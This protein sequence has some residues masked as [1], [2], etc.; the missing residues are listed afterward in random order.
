MQIYKSFS[1][2]PVLLF[3]LVILTFT[4]YAQDN[5][6]TKQIEL[7]NG[8]KVF[9]Y[10]RHSVPL[11]NLTFAVNCGSKDE[12]E[13]TSGIVHI[14]EHYIMFR[15]TEFRNGDELAQDIREHGAYFNAH[16]SRDLAYFEMTLPSKNGD[17]GLELQK[18]ILF[19]LK[20][21]QEELDEEKE[22]ILEE[23][24]KIFDDPM[25]YASAMAYQTLFAGHPYQNPIYGNKEA[26]KNLTVDQVRAFYSRFFTPNNS[27]LVVLGDFD[28]SDMEEKVKSLYGDLIRKDIIDTKYENISS[29]SE[30]VRIEKEMDVNL[31]YLV[32]GMIGPDY[33]HPDR[34]SID[35]LSEILGRGVN[36]LLYKPLSQRRL[37]TN[38]LSLSYGANKN[39]GAIFVSVS[40]DPKN[41]NI[42]EKEIIKYL[43]SVRRE[44]F[45]KD[46]FAGESQFYAMDYLEYAKNQIKF[47][48]HESQ[49]EGLSVALSLS[50]YLL[51]DESSQ[52]GSFLENIE[53][54]SSSDLRKAGGRYLGSGR[55][56]IV[57]ITPPKK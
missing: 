31:G 35:L 15:G 16:T 30:S 53:K 50:K 13:K 38:S 55:Y 27:A 19:N 56:V 48:A 14:L 45:S 33:N 20:L 32:I 28:I 44:S 47:R 52:E 34:F 41:I 11:I 3:L 29:L 10:E 51:M 5:E 6:K 57:S 49:E 18:E 39:A 40:L 7:D 43:K 37:Y 8:L 25:R 1:S 4:L 26:I 2:F 22:V 24:N 9:L 17:F 46:D 12:T 23:I 21:T 42:V 36:P 54:L